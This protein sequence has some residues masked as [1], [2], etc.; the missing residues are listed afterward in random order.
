MI[1]TPQQFDDLDLCEMYKTQIDRLMGRT[2]R[3]F[4]GVRG[5]DGDGEAVRTAISG[6]TPS[7]VNIGPLIPLDK[8]HSCTINAVYHIINTKH[9]R[10]NFKKLNDEL[11]EEYFESIGDMTRNLADAGFTDLDRFFRH[12]GCRGVLMRFGIRSITLERKT[13]T[14]PCYSPDG[15]RGPKRVAA[16]SYEEFCKELRSLSSDE[17]SG[18]IF[19]PIFADTLA[20]NHTVAA[21]RVDGKEVIF[22]TCPRAQGGVEENE[23]H[24]LSKEAMGA[25]NFRDD[26]VHEVWAVTVAAEPKQKASSGKRPAAALQEG[27]DERNMIATDSDDSARGNGRLRQVEATATYIDASITSNSD[28]EYG[29][30]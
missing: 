22:E 20:T 21:A 26:S 24:L 1:L 23:A 30:Y 8:G 13:V 7:N 11:F 17:C 15:S 2:V 10:V 29:K 25:L 28:D 4:Q 18:L 14:N 27:L 6:L 5:D 12:A 19:A 3:M 9:A 16:M